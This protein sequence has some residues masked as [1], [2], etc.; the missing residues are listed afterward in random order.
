MAKRSQEKNLARGV[1]TP[2]I[3]AKLL[4]VHANTVRYWIKNN[5]LEPLPITGVRDKVVPATRVLAF[6]KQHNYPVTKELEEA[7]A[8]YERTLAGNQPKPP[9]QP[10]LN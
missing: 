3:I 1:C 7:A 4:N 9:P 2:P 8:T 5:S 10:S 6:A